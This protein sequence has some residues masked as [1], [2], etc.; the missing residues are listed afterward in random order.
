LRHHVPDRGTT[1]QTEGPL[2]AGVRIADQPSGIGTGKREL[3]TVEL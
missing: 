1:T 2:A 3:G